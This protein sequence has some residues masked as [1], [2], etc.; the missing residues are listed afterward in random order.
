MAQLTQLSPIDIMQRLKDTDLTGND[1]PTDI[2]RDVIR[3]LRYTQTGSEIAHLLHVSRS[4]VTRDLCVIREADADEASD[5]TVDK[6]AGETISIA[7]R[8]QTRA[9]K[10]KDYAFVWRIQIS[11]IQQL[12]SIGYIHKEAEKL[13]VGITHS[14][15][16]VPEDEIDNQFG[17]LLTRGQAQSSRALAGEGTPSLN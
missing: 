5:L 2:R 7:R 16:D 10:N 14:F 13:G 15:K 3:M 6:I 11:L 8:I 1:L 12:Q 9:M 4:T 17:E